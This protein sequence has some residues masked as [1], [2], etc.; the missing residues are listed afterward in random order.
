MSLEEDASFEDAPLLQES[1][2]FEDVPVPEDAPMMPLMEAALEQITHPDAEELLS[3]TRRAI[4]SV[5]GKEQLTRL[6]ARYAELQARIT[7]RGGD[8]PRLEELRAQAEALNPD[9]WVTDE[10]AR[11]GLQ[12][13]DAKVRD[14][15]ASLG[16]RPRRRSRRGGRRRRRGGQGSPSGSQ[17]PNQAAGSPDASREGAPAESPD[18]SKAE[19][20]SE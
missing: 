18:P 16:L 10:E 17:G 15:R 6:R 7:E 9:S 5:V 12:G 13:F 1:S 20:F 19:D 8:A 14:L 2:I 4:E 3:P 11:K